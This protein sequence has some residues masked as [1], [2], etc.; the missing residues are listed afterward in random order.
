MGDNQLSFHGLTGCDT[1]SALGDH[2]SPAGKHSRSI[3][4]LPAELVMMESSRQLKF[5]CHLYGTLEQP[6]T[7]H[8][9]L[10]LFYKDKKGLEMLL[11]S[12]DVLEL[13]AIRANYQAKKTKE[14]IDIPPHLPPQPGRGMQ[15]LTAVWQKT[16]DMQLEAKVQ[17]CPLFLLQD[18]DAVNCSMWMW[19]WQLL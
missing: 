3:H 1:T 17:D 8:A 16:G 18:E 15:S 11:P 19:C 9:R 2:G 6:T 13:R 12:R 14:R 10:Q 5:V 4:F 7:N